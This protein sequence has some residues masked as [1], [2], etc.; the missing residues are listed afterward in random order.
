MNLP[1]ISVHL[2]LIYLVLILMFKRIRSV[3]NTVIIFEKIV[4]MFLLIFKCTLF[5]ALHLY[6]KNCSYKLTGIV[7]ITIITSISFNDS[8]DFPCSSALLFNNILPRKLLIT[9][10]V[11]TFLCSVALIL[12]P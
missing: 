3:S 2:V 5:T 4:L 11:I 8:C 7:D 1:L 9:Y 10:S 12:S 6:F